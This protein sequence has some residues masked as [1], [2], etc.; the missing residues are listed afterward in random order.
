MLA[1]ISHGCA[2]SSTGATPHHIAPPECEANLTMRH[3]DVFKSNIIPMAS[4]SSALVFEARAERLY[5]GQQEAEDV[6]VKERRVRGDAL[7]DERVRA[8]LFARCS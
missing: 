6:V 1:C 7:E 4:G 3:S 2:G 8:L 5:P